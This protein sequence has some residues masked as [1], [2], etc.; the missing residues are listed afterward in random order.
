MYALASES[1]KRIE[2]SNLERDRVLLK[3]QQYLTRI[4][5]LEEQLK[6]ESTERQERHDR[7]VESLRQK[8]KTVLE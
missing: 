6:T 8:H 2:D 4:S 3:E 7:V 5:R 1:K